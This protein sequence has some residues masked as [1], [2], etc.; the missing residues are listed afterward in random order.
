MRT[1]QRQKVTVV[2]SSRL[3]PEHGRA[4]TSLVIG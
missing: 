2:V 4:A 1:G 3:R